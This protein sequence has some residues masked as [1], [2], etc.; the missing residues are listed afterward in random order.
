MTKHLS[1]AE[2][3]DALEGTLAADRAAHA[4][5]CGTCGAQIEE[6]RA[7]MRDVVEAGAVP[8]PSPLMWD[9]LQHRIRAATAAESPVLPLWRRSWKPAVALGA[10]AATALLA[11]LLR[12][13]APPAP[14][15]AIE[16]AVTVAAA[17]PVEEDYAWDLVV[18][19]A[20][21]L[22]HDDV[23]DLAPSGVA[24]A[25]L[26]ENMT[27]REREALVKLIQREMGGLE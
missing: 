23:H 9:V 7:V 3:I 19:L 13:P 11:A 17:V 12:T 21:N 27:P 26:V 8:E 4:D 6:L 14:A 2:T 20:A 5:A 24:S 15:P 25:V 18:N 22:S 16:P 1:P 10:I